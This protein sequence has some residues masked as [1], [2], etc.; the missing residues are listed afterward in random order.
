MKRKYIY[1][2][3]IIILGLEGLFYEKKQN[4]QWHSHDF[5]MHFNFFVYISIYCW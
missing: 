4:K 2:Y 3:L 5:D 1:I